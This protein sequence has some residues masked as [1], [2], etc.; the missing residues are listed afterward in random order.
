METS[1][2]EAVSFQWV[3]HNALS[4]FVLGS[5]AFVPVAIFLNLVVI[6][7]HTH[8]LTFVPTAPWY[9]LLVWWLL[10][11]ILQFLPI[12]TDTISEYRTVIEDRADAATSAYAAV[13]AALDQRH[14][15]VRA[16]PTRIRSDILNREVVNNRLLVR[17]R[18][19]EI[20][21]TVFAYGTSLYIGWTMYRNRRR[22]ILVRTYWKDLIWKDLLGG[23]GGRSGDVNQ[24][25]RTEKVRA[26]REAVHSAVLEGAEAAM[27]RVEVP[28]A[29][30]FG[31]DLP[32]HDLDGPDAPA[33]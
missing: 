26:M 19:Y 3:L 17:D 13:F 24:M 25:L 18:S 22:H 5:L 21:V 28:L 20:Y 10:V 8:G 23:I 33:T 12:E 30:T 15:P 16:K 6:P 27:N 32:I 31:M 14:I 29:A 9:Q 11:T 4:S 1:L 2:S 7:L